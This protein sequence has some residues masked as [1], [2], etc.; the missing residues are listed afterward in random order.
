VFAGPVSS[1]TLLVVKRPGRI[2]NRLSGLVDSAIVAQA[3]HN[4]GARR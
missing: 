4:A 1:P 3:A 2:V